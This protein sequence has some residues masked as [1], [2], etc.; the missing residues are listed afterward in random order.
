MREWLIVLASELAVGAM[1]VDVVLDRGIPVVC[2][3]RLV[4]EVL[5]LDFV[6][7]E[8]TRL[9]FAARPVFLPK[10]E[11]PTRELPRLLD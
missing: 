1:S 9:L 5:V 4:S 2:F 10:D 3:G 6:S 11:K 7:I 8:E